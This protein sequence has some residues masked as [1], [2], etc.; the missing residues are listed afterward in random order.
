MEARGFTLLL[1]NEVEDAEGLDK[2]HVGVT[3]RPSGPSNKDMTNEMEMSAEKCGT[4]IPFYLEP[5]R[6]A[7]NWISAVLYEV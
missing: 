6:R 2:E 3:N 7:H 4:H 1:L 5:M